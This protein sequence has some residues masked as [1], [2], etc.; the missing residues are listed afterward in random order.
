M[1]WAWLAWAICGAGGLAWIWLDY[2]LDRLEV[3]LMAT[4]L[5]Q[6]T[7]EPPVPLPSVVM[8]PPIAR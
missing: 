2:R 8:A 4:P 7:E 1:I 3:L 6:P 5:Q